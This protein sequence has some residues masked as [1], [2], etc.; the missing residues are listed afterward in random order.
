M[1]VVTIIVFLTIP[2][3]LLG[4]YFSLQGHQYGN[5]SEVA[6]ED[7]GE[8]SNALLCV[9]E[10]NPR[11]CSGAGEFYYPNCSR[12]PLNRDGHTFWRNRGKGQSFIRLNLRPN[13]AVGVSGEGVYICDIPYPNNVL[14]ILYI[15]L[16]KSSVMLCIIAFILIQ[17][18]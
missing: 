11:C 13:R 8:G 5:N 9:S 18:Q 14:H 4:F 3:T 17:S 15:S 6:I 1:R 10:H 12:V 16:G 7:I 2:S